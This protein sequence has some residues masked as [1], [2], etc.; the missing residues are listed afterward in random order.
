MHPRLGHFVTQI[1]RVKEVVSAMTYKGNEPR[2]SFFAEF[3]T[4][5]FFYFCVDHDGASQIRPPA[6]LLLP[7]FCH[8]VEYNIKR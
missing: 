5:D 6:L 1:T 7:I 8:S 2:G 3:L 4:K